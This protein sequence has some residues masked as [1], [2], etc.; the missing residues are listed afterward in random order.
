MSMEIQDVINFVGAQA[1]FDE[2]PED[3]LKSLCGK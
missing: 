3:E 2:L 1:P